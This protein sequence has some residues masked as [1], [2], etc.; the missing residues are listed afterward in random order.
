[1]TSRPGVVLPPF[2]LPGRGT[3]QL[4]RPDTRT[5]LGALRFGRVTPIQHNVK[6]HKRPWI[7]MGCS[8]HEDEWTGRAQRSSRPS[9][10]EAWCEKSRPGMS[11]GAANVVICGW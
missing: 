6:I 11:R 3:Q 2:T 10:N 5:E 1:M 9:G 7:A 8:G 4:N